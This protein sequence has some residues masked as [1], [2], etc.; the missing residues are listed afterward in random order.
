MID[1][2]A[3]NKAIEYTMQ[4][5]FDKAEA[6]YKKLLDKEPDDHILLSAAGLFYADIR[7]VELSRKYS[8]KACSI[9]PSLST[10]SS[11]GFA[12]YE[13]GNYE[14]AA[15]A[16]AKSLEY[17]ETADIYNILIVSLFQI[18]NLAEALKFAKMMYEKYPNDKNAVAHH[19]KALTQSGQLTDAEKLC[20]S[21]LKEHDDAAVLWVHLGFL[22]E[23]IYNDNK[24]SLECFKKAASLGNINAINNIAM[25]YQKE[26]DFEN[27]GKYYKK[28]LEFHPDSVD[29][30]VSYGMC[31][32]KQRNFKEGFDQFFHRNKSQLYK[33]SK[34]CWEPGKEFEKEV[35]VISDQGYGDH[36][37]FSRYLPFLKEKTE[38]LIVIAKDSM[39]DLFKNNFPNIEFVRSNE[40]NPEIQSIRITD[41]AY[42]LNMDF[43]NIPSPDGYLKAR[44]ADIHSEK[45]KIG[46]C[47]EAGSAGVKTLLNRT[48]HINQFT[49]I[50]NLENIQTYSFQ[51]EDTLQ[52]N[53]KFPQMINLAKDF[54]NFEDTA[55]AINAMDLIITVDTSVAHLAGALGKKTWLLLPYVSDWRWFDD[56]KTTPWYNS[57]EIFKQT[58]PAGWDTQFKEMECRLKEFSL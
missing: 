32:L 43:G 45:P 58:S 20:T 29:T 14:D 15:K 37:Q 11:K 24:Q 22:K 23:L 19:V 3:L 57:I 54:K 13:M 38:K 18:G 21:Y 8:D 50:L 6:L 51:Y 52:G 28:M 40:F 1:L 10:F 33:D 2:N 25:C 55:Q 4:G 36:I 12:E 35:L 30:K 49:G 56:T 26:G 42:A 27:A 17:G 9:N 53:K 5:Q 7:N 39:I 48:I 44:T 16:L 46:L 31:L 41:L 47:W 34:N